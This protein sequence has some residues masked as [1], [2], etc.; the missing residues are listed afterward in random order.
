MVEEDCN[1]GIEANSNL[2]VDGTS[3]LDA[4]NTVVDSVS[5]V[6]GSP[7]ETPSQGMLEEAFADHVGSSSKY[8]NEIASSNGD[9]N[10]FCVAGSDSAADQE[11]DT[12]VAASDADPIAA[13]RHKCALKHARQRANR[14]TKMASVNALAARVR[15]AY[16][17]DGI[18]CFEAFLSVEDANAAVQ[19]TCADMLNQGC[20]CERFVPSQP[21]QY[22]ICI[23]SLGLSMIC[24]ACDEMYM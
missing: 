4:C 7:W 2:I 9:R 16:G 10:H 3:Y 1:F 14:A 24:K 22:C 23:N 12:E 5:G 19:M 20:G 18:D 15:A 21:A 8:S 17:Q 6:V 13:K 11:A